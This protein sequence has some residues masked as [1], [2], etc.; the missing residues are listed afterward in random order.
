MQTESILRELNHRIQNNFQI[1]LSLMNLKKRM[2]PGDH[3]QDLRFIEEHVQSMAIAYR[4]VYATGEMIEVSAADLIREILSS[5]RHIA[6]LRADCLVLDGFGFT[7]AIGLDQAITLGLYLAITVPPMLDHAVQTGTIVT[8]TGDLQD[9][10]LTL[11]V[12]VAARLPIELDYLRTRL[13]KAY[14]EH[15]HAERLPA[16]DPGERQVRFPID[17]RRGAVFT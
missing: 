11:S 2:P 4:L 1:I 14:L 10:L 8:A 5:L 16:T 7:E 15:L 13:M 17:P 6:G 12:A 3:Q 9:G